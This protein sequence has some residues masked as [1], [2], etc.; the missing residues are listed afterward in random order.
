MEASMTET[1]QS[2]PL[3]WPTGWRRSRSRERARFHRRGDQTQSGWRPKQ[4]LSVYDSIGRVLSELEAMGLNR[5]S[6]VVSSNVPTRLDGLPRSNAS[7][8]QDP[9]AAV[10]WRNGKS[11]TR[12]M[13][14]D[15]Y[16]RVADNLAAIAATL[17]AMRAI[18][19]HGGAA[20]LDRAFT[21]FKALMAA[22]QWFQ[23]L[24][25]DSPDVTEEQIQE[26]YLAKARQS[27]PDIPGGDPTAMAR[28]NAARDRGMEEVQHDRQRTA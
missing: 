11:G 16:D 13:G 15:R 25:L 4:E 8:P 22:E 6:I 19:R 1:I 27:H 23:V 14:V 18:E 7:E 24:G 21:G 26:A 17:G 2:Y 10:Y 5:D 20:I 9:G 28:I 3:Q 12:C